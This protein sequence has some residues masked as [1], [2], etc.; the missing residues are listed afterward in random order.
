MTKFLKIESVKSILVLLGVSLVLLVSFLGTSPSLH[1]LIHHDA[2]QADHHCVIT[3]FTKGQVTP[4]TAA[5]RLAVVIILFGGVVLLA[6]TFQLPTTDY[7]ISSSR[8]PPSPC[9]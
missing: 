4:A 9:F 2:D 7:C 6:K 8:A 3:L 1:K 5:Q